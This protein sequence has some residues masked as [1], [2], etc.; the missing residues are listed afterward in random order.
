MSIGY[1]NLYCPVGPTLRINGLGPGFKPQY[2]TQFSL[3]KGIPG[4][5]P[6]R[7]IDDD[8]TYE[9][10]MHDR[11]IVV[12]G[13][14]TNY[15]RE[16]NALTG[17]PARAITPF[18]AVTNSGDL[19]SRK[20]YTCGGPCQTFQSRPNLNGLK[21]RF[22]AV[23]LKCDG[24]NVEPAACNIKYVYDSSDYSRYLKQRSINQAY[25]N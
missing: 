2:R 3:G 18:R 16:I 19:L 21:Q 23:M 24:S 17:K 7:L 6:Q 12:E 8:Y 1:T 13:W 20:Y 5:I 11:D 9:D 22:G 25:K 14:N 4:F 10:Y 15:R